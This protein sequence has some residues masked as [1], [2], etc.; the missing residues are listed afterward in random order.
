MLDAQQHR[1]PD[2]RGTI[3][4][5]PV[6]M[7]QVRLSII[8]LERG[9][10][11]IPNEDETIWIV[12]N[13]EIYNHEIL[14]AR[15]RELGHS[16][17]TRS[18]SEVIIHLYEEYGEDCVDH[19]RGMF[20]F[21]IWDR[22][23]QRLL[24]ARD[25]FGQK[26]FYY[27]LINGKFY[28]SSEIKG[29]LAARPE[30]RQPDLQAI[31]QYLAL[32]FVAAPRSMFKDVRKL[33]PA[34]R[35]IFDLRC[36]LKIDRYWQLD[37]EPKRRISLQDAIEETKDRLLETLRLHMISDV[38]VGA[39]LSGGLDSGL[40]T[41][42]LC[43]EVLDQPLK[44]FTLALNHQEFDESPAAKAVA[45]QCATEHRAENVSPS[46]IEFLPDLVWHLD[47]PSDPLSLCTYLVAE[48]AARHV[49]VVLGGDGGDELFGGYD[50]YYGV[51]FADHY[52]RIPG[53]VRN[54]VL[55]P[56]VESNSGGSW[57][58]SRTH[59]L[60]WL[61][62]LARYQ[63]GERYAAALN[64]FY[65]DAGSRAGLYGE[66]MQ[67]VADTFIGESFIIDRYAD[68]RAKTA[69]DRMLA[70]DLEGR[71]PDHPVMI[72][73]RMTMAH[74]LE[75]RSPFMDHKLA[76]YCARL[77]GE[78]KVKGKSLRIL[79]REIA[80]QY[81]PPEVLERPKQGFASAMPYMLRSEYPTMFNVLLRDSCLVKDGFL[82]ADSISTVLED[83]LSEKKDHATRLWLLANSEI[84][85]RMAIRNESRESMR[86]LFRTPSTSA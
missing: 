34:H 29:L 74:G 32:R 77:P 67:P 23:Q 3:A 16:F 12:C 31:D 14:R 4:D 13:G 59:Q 54:A 71:L 24:A 63:G 60:K 33:P 6:D 69:L 66:N 8:D 20:A 28:F 30:L 72:T 40:V 52:A 22:R 53:F 9:H 78:L 79:Q 38:P 75:A 49:K 45:L 51:Q 64:Y 57:Y 17:R 62:R 58:K 55:E 37:Y 50:R 15:L 68:A 42:M 47:E 48:L 83:H 86:E 18:D 56:L 11:P 39:F 76:E 7:G 80:K 35:L 41:A 85:Y 21:V 25:H 19:L 82:R 10:Q 43:K 5:P 61:H 65:F 44:T 1:G 81:L 73:D 46:M 84:W 2:D 26:P 27:S 36:G 70:T